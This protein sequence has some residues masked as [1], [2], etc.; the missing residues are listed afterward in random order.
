MLRWIEATC[1]ME[2]AHERQARQLTSTEQ[3][4]FVLTRLLALLASQAAPLKDAPLVPGGR[5]FDSS[6]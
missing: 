5:G 6:L 4:A 1:L 3:A 2:P